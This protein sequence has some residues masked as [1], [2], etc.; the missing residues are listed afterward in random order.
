M[1]CQVADVITFNAAKFRELFPAYSNATA[2]PDTLLAIKWE[3]AIGY[4]S[5]RNCGRMTDAVR[6]YAIMLCLAH[7]LTLDAY[8]ASNGG[9]GSAGIV[10]SSSI[11]KVSVS[12]APP[13]ITSPWDYWLQ[14]TPYG[15]QLLAQLSAASVGGFYVGGLPER[16]AFRKVGGVW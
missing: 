3:I 5:D 16:S 8:I 7:L 4:V 11:D 15:S 1:G 10:T 14:Q 2:Y 9:Q 12:L 6:E 13:P